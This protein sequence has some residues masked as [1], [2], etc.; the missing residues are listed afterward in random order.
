MI[1]KKVKINTTRDA[2]IRKLHQSSDL[3]SCY[4][5][6]STSGRR[7]CRQQVAPTYRVWS[8]AACRS[9]R[10]AIIKPPPAIFWLYLHSYCNYECIGPDICYLDT[11]RL[12]QKPSDIR[13]CPKKQAYQTM[14][15]GSQ[16]VRVPAAFFYLRRIPAD[17]S[18]TD[19]RVWFPV[20]FII[21]I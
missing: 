21:K 4:Q 13:T 6:L 16:I 5:L 18:L 8:L 15:D 12:H 1:Q 11:H 7:I 20:L 19:T 2:E 17:Y 10:T 14:A 3:R 9:V